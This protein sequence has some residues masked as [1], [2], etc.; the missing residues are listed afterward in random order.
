M[1]LGVES[2]LVGKSGWLGVAQLYN[3]MSAATGESRRGDSSFNVISPAELS[4]RASPTKTMINAAGICSG[5]MADGSSFLRSGRLSPQ[6][7]NLNEE[8]GESERVA[9]P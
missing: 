3:N 2:S 5:I 6:L 7:A 9:K 1:A 4:A 8:G